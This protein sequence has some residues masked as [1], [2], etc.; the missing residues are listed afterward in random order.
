MDHCRDP[1]LEVLV[2]RVDALDL[3]LFFLELAIS[4]HLRTLGNKSILLKLLT[5]SEYKRTMMSTNQ[6]TDRTVRTTHGRRHKP[7]NPL[8]KVSHD[9][10][11]IRNV[12]TVIL[13]KDAACPHHSLGK[14]QTRGFEHG[15]GSV[16]KK[17]G[18]HPRAV[19]P[20]TP[21]L[22]VFFSIKRFIF[23]ES[24]IDAEPSPPVDIVRI[25]FLVQ[26]VS[27]PLTLSRVSK[28]FGLI[29]KD[30]TELALA[31]LS[32]NIIPERHAGGLH[33]NLHHLP[34][35]LPCFH[36]IERFFNRFGHGF[37]A[38]D[39]QSCVE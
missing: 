5:G 13:E 15:C 39:M 30:L 11:N 31:E 26:L 19:G 9:R 17:I 14:S 3:V 6:L 37:F 36:Y 27:S 22:A 24:F 21:P 18:K 20:E 29:L 23:S 33:T 28:K 7:L 8:V 12:S 25:H 2:G 38:V 34:T 1:V 32:I 35:L 16:H 10:R 4:R